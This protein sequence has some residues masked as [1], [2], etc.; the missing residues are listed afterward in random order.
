M[1]S[2]SK[3]IEKEHKHM[4]FTVGVNF[5][6]QLEQTGRTKQYVLVVVKRLKL[7]RNEFVI[8]ARLIFRYCHD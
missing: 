2:L 8:L 5:V 6:A 1:P 7:K 4:T 3:K